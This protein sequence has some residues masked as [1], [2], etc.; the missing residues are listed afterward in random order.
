VIRDT[1]KVALSA[2]ATDSTGQVYGD[3]LKALK[4]NWQLAIGNWLKAA[5]NGRGAQ[6]RVVSLFFARGLPL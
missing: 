6:R 1:G 5:V 2:S 3:W 4:G